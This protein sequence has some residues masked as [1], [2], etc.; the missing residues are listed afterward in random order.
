MKKIAMTLSAASVIFLSAFVSKPTEQ[1]TGI[2]GTITP[3]ES[4][5]KVWAI[6]G[7]DSV[8]V[9]PTTG[10]FNLEVKAGTYKLVVEAAAPYKTATVESVVVEE[11][12]STDAGEIKLASE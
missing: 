2:H 3:A 8:S 6:S 9:A 10:S 1:T 11:G 12:K 5:K 7:T 4:A